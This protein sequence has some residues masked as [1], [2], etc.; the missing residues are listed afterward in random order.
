MS[1][2][3]VGYLRRSPNETTFFS[4]Y[5][6]TAAAAD[7]HGSDQ[8]K[9]RSRATLLRWS[10]DILEPVECQQLAVSTY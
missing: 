8:K 10:K 6:S 5:G 1:R 7:A 9:R 4:F 2:K 3:N